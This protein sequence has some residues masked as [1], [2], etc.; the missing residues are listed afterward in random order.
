VPLFPCMKVKLLGNADR[1][2]SGT[3]AALIVRITVVV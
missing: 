1:L 2:K 3:G